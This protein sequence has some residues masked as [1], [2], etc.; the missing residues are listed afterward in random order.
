MSFAYPARPDVHVFRSFSLKVPAGKTVALV[1]QSGSGKSTVVG[2]IER[3]YDP[4]AG[5]VE[6]DGVN[7]R[8]LKL[9]WLRSLVGLGVVL[10]MVYEWRIALVVAGGAGLQWQAL[11]P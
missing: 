7:V 2:L 9:S 4:A 8:D 1:G 3:L 6:L 11:R 5:S 10:A